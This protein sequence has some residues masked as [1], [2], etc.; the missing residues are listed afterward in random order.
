MPVREETD[1]AGMQT[2]SSKTFA[3]VQKSK[4]RR[5]SK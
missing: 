1:L 4:S 3:S 5:E 2:V